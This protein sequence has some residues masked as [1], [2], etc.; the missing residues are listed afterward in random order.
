[1]S[2][3][4]D[5]SGGEL[6][7]GGI[8]S[9]KYTGPINYVKLSSDTYWEFLVS[10]FQLEGQSLGWCTKGTCKSICDTGTSLIT[11]P[12]SQIDALNKQLGAHVMFD[13]EAIFNCKVIDTLPD[14]EVIINNQNYTLTPQQYVLQETSNGVT[15]C[16]SGFMG[17][18]VPPPNGPL[19]ILGDVFI[20]AYYTIFDFG[21]QQVGFAV[22]AQPN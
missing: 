12:R 13:G 21:N 6:L 2:F 4:E 18:D 20:R 10:D 14:F 1:M 19:Y 16:I 8:D 17:L 22:N 9:T 15:S 11:G 5:S 3:E 7:L